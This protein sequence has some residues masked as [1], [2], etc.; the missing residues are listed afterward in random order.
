M[1]DKYKLTV[2][3]IYRELPSKLKYSF[4]R[5]LCQCQRHVADTKSLT[6]R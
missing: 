3:N 2:S 1:S 4:T 6:I 5:I